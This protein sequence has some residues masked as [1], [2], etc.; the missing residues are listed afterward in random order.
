MTALA[1]LLTDHRMSGLQTRARY[2]YFQDNFVGTLFD[3][4]PT[5]SSSSCLN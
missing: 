3:N 4:N 5:G 1:S 2:K